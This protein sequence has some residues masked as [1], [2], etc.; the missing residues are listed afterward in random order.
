M[1]VCAGVADAAASRGAANKA[2]TTTG[3]GIGLV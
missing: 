1:V 2:A 3:C